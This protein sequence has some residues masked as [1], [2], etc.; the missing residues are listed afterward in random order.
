M[1]WLND[2]DEFS[3]PDITHDDY[4]QFAIDSIV[5]VLF[6]RFN[7]TSSLGD[8]TYKGQVYDIPNHFFWMT[9]E[10]MM[11]IDG[12]PRPIWQ[13]C[14][15]AKPRFVSQWLT[16]RRGQF[17]PDALALLELGKD[18]VWAS[19]PHR[20]DALP[21]FQLDRWDAG[22]YQIRMGLFGK[23]DVP[24]QQPTEMMELMERFKVAYR[25]LGERLRPMIYTLGFLPSEKMIE[26]P[27]EEMVL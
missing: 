14:R 3:V 2:R 21:K 11:Q 6:N 1:S 18:L 13:Q 12:L 17:S 19:A 9:P 26:T 20:M 7:Q 15:T 24:F 5:W 23:K 16:E 4:G 27:I 8:V 22:W 25:E 10:E